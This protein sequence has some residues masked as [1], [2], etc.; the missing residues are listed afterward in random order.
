[1]SAWC[2]QTTPTGSK[3]NISY[4]KHMPNPLGTDIK[5]CTCPKAGVIVTLEI[6]IGGYE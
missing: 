5:F 1:M 2:P 3:P 4:V 6:Q